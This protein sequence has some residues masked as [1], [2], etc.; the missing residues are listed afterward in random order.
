MRRREWAHLAGVLGAALLVRAVLFRYVGIWGDAGFYISDAGLINQGLTPYVDFIGRSPLFN[1]AFAYI[2]G[3]FGN[4]M[5]V[6]RAFIAFWWLL[7]LFPV[8]WIPRQIHGHR[9]GVA[10]G[11]AMQLTPFMLVFGYWANTQSLA[12]LLA[13]LAVAS[14]VWR[15]DRVGFALAGVFLGA[16]FLSRRSVIT[17]LGA[18]L[19][20]A[21]Y[22]AWERRAPVAMVRQQA[23]AGAGFLA[24]LMVGYLMLADW[25]PG[26]ALA[27]AETHGW[28][29]ISSA[30]RGG[31]PLLTTTDPPDVTNQLREGRIPIFNDLCQMCGAWTARTFAKT[32]LVTVPV[33]GPMLWYF[34]DWSDRWFSDRLRDYTF[35]VLL[36]L[37]AY[38]IYSALMAG[39][40]LR[41]FVA[42]VL[43]VFGVLAFRTPAIDRS[44]LYHR[45][46]VFCGLCLG[47]LSAGYV[48]RNRVLHTYYFSDFFP[49]LSVMVGVVAVAAWEVMDGE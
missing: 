27:F 15:E 45:H 10:A 32:T 24:V 25:R 11:A 14:V 8:Y 49:F 2:A 18:V 42:L 30:G 33:I 40:Y 38:G 29:L 6:L 46:M 31:F 12:A 48:Y 21:G 17:I 39:F 7:C 3:V 28:G 19:L 44:I 34:R 35:G 4:E 9:A 16:A 5:E 47:G 23:S 13:V 22:R 37:A 36:L 20:Y 43:V 41:P 26:L 1:Y